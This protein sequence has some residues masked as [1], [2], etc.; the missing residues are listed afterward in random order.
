[1]PYRFQRPYAMFL[2]CHNTCITPP[3]YQMSH[4]SQTSVNRNWWL[5]RRQ[6]S[7]TCNHKIEHT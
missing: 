7:L 3:L 1:M 2:M 4:L 5:Q 6:L